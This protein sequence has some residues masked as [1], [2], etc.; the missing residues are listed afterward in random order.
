MN[1]VSRKPTQICRAPQGR[2]EGA[3]VAVLWGV[4]VEASNFKPVARLDIAGGGQVS[5]L[6]DYA[7]VGHMDA[8]FGTSI[9][10]ISNPSRPKVVGEVRLETSDIHSHKARAIQGGDIMITNC[11]RASRGFFRRGRDAVAM[12]DRLKGELGRDPT[13]AEIG[14]AGEWDPAVVPDLL[15]AGKVAFDTGGFR[16]WDIRDK[17]NPKMLAHVNTGGDGSHRFDVDDNYLY[18]SSGREGFVGNILQIYDI[19]TAEKPELVSLWWL[20][21]QNVGAGEVPTWKGTRNQLHHAM[22]IGNEL[23]AGCWYGGVRGIDV[24]DI[25]KPRTIAEYDYHPAFFHPTHTAMRPPFK[26]GGLDIVVVMDEEAE[27]EQGRE[28]AFL[29]FF[30]ISDGKS[31]KPISTFHVNEGD[32]PYSRNGGQF[33]AHQYQEHFGRPLLFGTWFSGGL[34]AV[35]FSNPYEPKETGY[36]ILDPGIKG[37]NVQTNDVEADKRGL[38]YIL[39]RFQGLDVVEYTG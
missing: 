1:R 31:M 3:A 12:R 7:Y 5:V 34:R 33:G 9:V 25:S 11:E 15:E 16:V 22:R 4:L 28:H 37:K 39:D 19:S 24:S 35:D 8:P 13:A 32:S 38:V 27:H 23:W 14:A 26:V 36:F 21:G 10:D 2:G 29:W 30:D 20:P 6:G 18:I 17:A